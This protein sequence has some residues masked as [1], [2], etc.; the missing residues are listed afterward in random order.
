MV[1]RTEF[2]RFVSLVLILG[3]GA[4][5]A[6]DG[7]GMAGRAY[8]LEHCSECHDI[9]AGRQRPIIPGQAPAFA[10]IA[11]ASTTTALGLEVFLTTP[12]AKMPNFVIAERD[13]HDIVAYIGS[14]RRKTKAP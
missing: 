13:R 6:Q 4:A 1:M 3:A 9:G 11:N 8:A 14:L 12:H 10:A 5:A 2:A 7:D